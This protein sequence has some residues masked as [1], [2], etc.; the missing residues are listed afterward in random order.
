MVGGI[1]KMNV[2]EHPAADVE[3]FDWEYPPPLDQ[4]MRK[5]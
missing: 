4:F 3:F 5:R 2:D 1:R